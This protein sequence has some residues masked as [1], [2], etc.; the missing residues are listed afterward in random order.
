MF[1]IATHIFEG[2]NCKRVN[3]PGDSL[4]AEDSVLCRREGALG[5]LLS[6]RGNDLSL[7][8]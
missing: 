3:D 2:Q 7:V 1:R 4:R 5:P 8:S 6:G